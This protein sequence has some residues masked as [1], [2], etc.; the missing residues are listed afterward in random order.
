MFDRHVESLT[1]VHDR[2][3]AL[4]PA[5]EKNAKV[6]NIL[7]IGNNCNCTFW[8]LRKNHVRRYAFEGYVELVRSWI[9]LSETI[10]TAGIRLGNSIVEPN[11]DFRY[12]SVGGFVELTVIIGIQINA[13]VDACP[14]KDR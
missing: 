11:L 6:L 7:S 3:S 4:N 10:L 9:D 2:D 5:G 14:R 8:I 13:A 1:V 12:R